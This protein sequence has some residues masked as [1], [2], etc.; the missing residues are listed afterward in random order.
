[1]EARTVVLVS[2]LALAGCT[3]PARY[4]LSP[5]ATYEFETVT[6]Q[7]VSAVDSASTKFNVDPATARYVWERAE[8]F[9]RHYLGLSEKIAFTSNSKVLGGSDKHGY[10]WNVTG[11]IAEE[12]GNFVVGC[13]ARGNAASSKLAELNAKN[14]ARFLNTG[15]LE[16]DLLPH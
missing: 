13:E 3:S 12:T 2:L 5:D 8:F 16:V 1:M 14:L 4:A 7:A 6:E 15:T 10:Q 11:G 9:Y